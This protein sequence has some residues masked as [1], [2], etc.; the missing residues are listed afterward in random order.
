MSNIDFS[1]V[2]SAEARAAATRAEH[3]AAVKLE[4]RTRILAVVDETAQMN[5]VHAASAALLDAGTMAV[6]R[7][8]VNWISSMRLACQALIEEPDRNY[9][10]DVFWP[11]VPAGVKELADRF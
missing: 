10:D 6:H 4:C 8:G 3:A 5:L 9:R 11:A 1:Q 2:V 7:A